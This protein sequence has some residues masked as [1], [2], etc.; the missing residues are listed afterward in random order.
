[1][2]SCFNEILLETA[3]KFK[4]LPNGVDKTAIALKLFGRSGKDMIPVL[5][6]GS[7]G[8]QELQKKSR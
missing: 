4:G 6:L 7:K 1:M 8:I 5:N 3:D 2:F